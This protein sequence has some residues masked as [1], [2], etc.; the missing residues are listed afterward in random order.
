MNTILHDVHVQSWVKHHARQFSSKP[1]ANGYKVQALHT[2]TDTNGN[3]THW[4]IRLK[5]PDTGDKWIRPM[6]RTDAG[7]DLKQPDYQN[8][9]PLYRLHELAA[10][11]G[12]PVMIVEGETCTDALAKLDVLATTSGS[13]DS[14][15]KADLSTLAGRMVMILPDNDKAGQHYA[16]DVKARLEALGCTVAV[17]DVNKLGLPVKGDVVDWLAAHPDA[18]AADV[19]AL[20]VV[21]APESP[22]SADD[23][24]DDTQ[25]QAVA[26]CA[27]DVTLEPISWLWP[28]WLAAGKLHILAGAP[29][30]GKTTLSLSLAATLTRSG[31]WPDGATYTQRSNVLIWSGEDDPA[32]TLVPRL[33]A[34]GADLKRVHFLTGTRDTK[35]GEILSF[36]P[37]RDIPAIEALAASMGGVSLLI[38]DPIVSATGGADSHKN[39]EV[40]RALQ[41]VVDIG[42][43]L[44][45]C[46]LGITHFSKGT[47]GKD[48]TERVTG[49]LAFGALA[50]VVL[51]AAKLSE[52][53]GG[54]RLLCRTKS[55]IGADHGGVKYDLLEKETP[56]GIFASYAAWGECVEG[57]ARELLATADTASDDGEGGTMSD[58]KRFLSD[59]LADRPLPVKTIKAE[60]DGAGYSWATIRRAKDA[61]DIE[62]SKSGMRGG[63]EWSISRR[64]SDN[65]ED[66]HSQSVSTFSAFDKNEHLHGESDDDR[67]DIVEV[68]F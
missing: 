36:D 9:T 51:A 23:A 29:G 37:S 54:G 16:A 5:H 57:T 19:W 28:G 58:V 50:R 25:Y 59:L 3:P 6:R 26:L 62:A 61:L 10:R 7:F 14:A 47:Q 21:N 13:A 43:L 42:W 64:C 46:I 48:P 41:P 55:N 27:A 24:V 20:P 67:G 45:C 44:D 56:G 33:S 39:A 1:I 52:D 60:A 68:E 66:A 11:P 53:D 49:S 40:R 35:S 8:G 34:A 30:T 18:T 65:P 63:W 2:Y 4:R 12:E 32:D 38:I 22:A 17:I 31:R 15:G